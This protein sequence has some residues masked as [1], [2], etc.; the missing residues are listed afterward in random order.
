MSKYTEVTP[1]GCERL[2]SQRE[3]AAR[4]LCSVA[5]AGRRIA[6][7]KIKP[8]LST[9]KNNYYKSS[10]IDEHRMKAIAEIARR[11]SQLNG[12]ERNRV[13]ALFAQISAAENQRATPNLEDLTAGAR[14]ANAV[15]TGSLIRELVAPR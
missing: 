8:A 14:G 11:C 7:G 2:N 1:E 4:M 13:V 9:A 15:G 6:F 3:L 5:E 10:D 12:S